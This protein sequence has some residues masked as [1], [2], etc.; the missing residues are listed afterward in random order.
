MWNTKIDEQDTPLD[1]GQGYFGYIA[2]KTFHYPNPITYETE[3]FLIEFPRRNPDGSLLSVVYPYHSSTG[4]LYTDSPIEL[5]KDTATGYRFAMENDSNKLVNG[6][7]AINQGLNM[8]TNPYMSHI[9]FEALYASNADKISNKIKYWNGETFTTYTAGNRILSNKDF[10]ETTIA[11][12]QGFFV[13]GL[14]ADSIDIDLATNFTADLS[15]N[16]TADTTKTLHI[17][18]DNGS[19]RSSTAIALRTNA[20]NQLDEKD[21]FKLFSQYTDVPEIFT[22]VEEVNLDINQF[23]TLPY[24]APIGIYS[25]L[26]GNINL[27]FEG[28]DSFENIDVILLNTNTGEQQDLKTNNQYTLSYQGESEVDGYLFIELRSSEITTNV[29]EEKFCK[30]CIRVYQK[31][32]NVIG[33]VSRPNDKIKNITIWEQ[34]GIL[35]YHSNK[36]NRSLLDVKVNAKNKTCVVRVSTENSSYVVKV[37]MQE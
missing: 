22:V 9:D 34:S 35:L 14:V 5:P 15:L 36:V 26:S 28:A 2:T 10:P 32:I 19:K 37:L 1:N 12:M 7:I 33:I 29:E 8:L 4:M 27:S 20:S 23:N 11:P 31:D 25:E 13:E 3:D 18:S 16:I 6:K 30:E 17:K 24:I 21:A